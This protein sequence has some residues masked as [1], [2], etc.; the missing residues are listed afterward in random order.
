MF[1]L[2]RKTAI[3]NLDP[4]NDVLPFTP[5]ID[6]SDLVSLENVQEEQKLGP[7]GG[8]FNLLTLFSLF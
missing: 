7:N 4:A 1:D 3:V 6:V 5:E 2:G 8:T